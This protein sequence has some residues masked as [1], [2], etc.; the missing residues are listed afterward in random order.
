MCTYMIL[1]ILVTSYVLLKVLFVCPNMFQIFF[2]SKPAND[3]W[4]K[5]IFQLDVFFMLKTV[6]KTFLMN[7]IFLYI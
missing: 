4:I 6:F 3:E 5:K 2:F 1:R 7:N